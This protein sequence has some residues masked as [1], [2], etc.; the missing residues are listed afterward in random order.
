MLNKYDGSALVPLTGAIR[1]DNGG[2]NCRG[3]RGKAV[4]IHG[5]IPQLDT[6]QHSKG[7]SVQDSARRTLA[8]RRL[9]L[10]FKMELDKQSLSPIAETDPLTQEM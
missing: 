8:S 4:H 10:G 9:V 3:R 6:E 7:Q 1:N 2:V 5:A